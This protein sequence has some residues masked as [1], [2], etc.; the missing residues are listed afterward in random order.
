MVVVEEVEGTG[1]DCFDFI[2]FRE[3]FLL[4]KNEEHIDSADMTRMRVVSMQ[5][6]SGS[7]SLSIK[8]R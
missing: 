8:P 2:T 6:S 5:S 3:Y 4:D 7:K 1:L